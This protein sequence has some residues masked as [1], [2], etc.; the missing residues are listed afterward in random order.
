MR[1]CRVGWDES[2]TRRDFAAH[3]VKPPDSFEDESGSATSWVNYRIG[4][5]AR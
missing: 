4:S 2:A 3:K 1:S 5:T